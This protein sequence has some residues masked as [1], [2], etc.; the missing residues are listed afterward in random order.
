[1]VSLSC[2]DN[3][4]QNLQSEF[5]IPF[6]NYNYGVKLGCDGYST[7]SKNFIGDMNMVINLIYFFT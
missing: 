4:V 7:R 1:M 2:D 6:I 3:S 5:E